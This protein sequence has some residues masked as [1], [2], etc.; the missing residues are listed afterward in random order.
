MISQV[1]TLHLNSLKKGIL[2]AVLYA[3]IISQ[4]LLAM[5]TILLKMSIMSTVL[6][7]GASFV[8]H[9]LYGITLGAIVSYGFPSTK[10]ISFKRKEKEL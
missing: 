10:I 5:T 4:P 3:E 7:Y 9:F 2:L 1:N 8:M 6:W